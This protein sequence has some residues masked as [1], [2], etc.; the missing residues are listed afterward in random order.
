MPSPI[1]ASSAKKS[2]LSSSLLQVP[3]IGA[4][5]A[6]ALLRQF[7]SLRNIR[8][9]SIEELLLVK[10]MTRPAAE[11]IKRAFPEETAGRRSRRRSK[12]CVYEN[13]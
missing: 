5:R 3:G 8:R 13:N 1:T 7:G 9:A 2:S 10:G 4:G 6:Q 11:A 12:L